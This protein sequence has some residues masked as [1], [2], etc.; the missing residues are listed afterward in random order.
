MSSHHSIEQISAM[1]IAPAKAMCMQLVSCIHVHAQNNAG[2]THTN[3]HVT[4]ALTNVGF[5]KQGSSVSFTTATHTFVVWDAF[6]NYQGE[7]ILI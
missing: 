2:S 3:M 1:T 4:I 5:H 6:H 7:Y